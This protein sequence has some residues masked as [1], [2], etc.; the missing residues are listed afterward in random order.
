MATK[1]V[2]EEKSLQDSTLDAFTMTNIMPISDTLDMVNKSFDVDDN[3]DTYQALE[4]E[5]END[6]DELTPDDE[7]I[8]A[9]KKILDKS[10]KSVKKHDLGDE[11]KETNKVDEDSDDLNWTPIYKLLEAELGVEFDEENMPEGS[12]KGFIDFVQGI[13]DENS[14]PKYSSNVVEQFDEFVKAGGNPFDFLEQN[15]SDDISEDI[16]LSDDD[17]Q[18]HVLRTYYRM[19]G[20]NEAKIDRMVS[21]SESAGDLQEEAVDAFEEIKEIKAKEREEM[22]AEQKR[23]AEAIKQTQMKFVENTKSYVESLDS[24]NDIKISKKDKEKVLPY[25]FSVDKD[26]KTPYQKAYEQD[27]VKFLVE[28]ALLSLIKPDIASKVKKETKNEIIKD[29]RR[30]LSKVSN[31]NARPGKGSSVY[32]DTEDEG[33]SAFERLAKGLK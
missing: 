5:E 6:G 17:A 26:G 2:K 18:K 23:Q 25:I 11:S 8:E 21:K 1:K 10:V 33:F 16:D 9:T 15:F 12:T 20:F 30:N 32:H 27:P 13:I 31:D 3:Q 14:K 28:S 29:I 19:K 24:I 7:G 22:L 4:L